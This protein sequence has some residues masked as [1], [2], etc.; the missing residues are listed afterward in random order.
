MQPCRC[1]LHR[2]ELR[3]H[4]ILCL[5]DGWTIVTEDGKKSAHFEH[6][7]A[8]TERGPRILTLPEGAS[9]EEEYPFPPKEN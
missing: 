6:T 3:F 8:F 9:E 4:S 1:S 7:I 5:E 2:Q